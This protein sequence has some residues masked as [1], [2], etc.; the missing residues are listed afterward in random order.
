[1][2][3]VLSWSLYWVGGWGRGRSGEGTT[4]TIQLGSE[5]SVRT[6][7]FGLSSSQMVLLQFRMVSVPPEPSSGPDTERM[8]VTD[9]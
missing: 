3:F 2:S 4:N 1:M 9:G 5:Q 7:S 6:F 8:T